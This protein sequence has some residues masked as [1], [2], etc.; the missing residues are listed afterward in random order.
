MN[1]RDVLNALKRNQAHT[2]PLRFGFSLDHYEL[3][4]PNSRLKDEIHRI[5]QVLRRQGYE[6]EVD[7]N[8]A[9]RETHFEFVHGNPTAHANAILAAAGHT[10]AE[11]RDAHRREFND[12]IYN[13]SSGVRKVQRAIV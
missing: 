13:K 12:S 7:E 6:L 9:R 5:I 2:L 10:R 11:I 3:N 8:Y 1:F 4:H